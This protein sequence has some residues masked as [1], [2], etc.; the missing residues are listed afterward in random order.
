MSDSHKCYR[1]FDGNDKTL[2]LIEFFND[3]NLAQVEKV[4]MDLLDFYEDMEGWS[5][6]SDDNKV[7]NKRYQETYYDGP[8]DNLHYT[9]E[10]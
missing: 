8:E 5:L 4:M 6:L 7:S 3:E 9:N 2:A 1:V 10:R